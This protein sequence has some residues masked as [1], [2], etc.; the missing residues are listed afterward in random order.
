LDAIRGASYVDLNHDGTITL[1]EFAAHVEADMSAAEE[2]LS[3][4]ATTK[5]FEREMVLSKAEP[6]AIQGSVNVRRRET[7]TAIG[8]P[9][10]S[11]TRAMRN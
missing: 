7:A 5:G 1:S 9:A 3:T 6:L 8:M 2:Q 11:W 10:G 4:F